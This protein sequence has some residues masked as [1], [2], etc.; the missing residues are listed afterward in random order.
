[1]LRTQ[2]KKNKK[3]MSG[4]REPAMEICVWLYQL[5]G[6][7]GYYLFNQCADMTNSTEILEKL[8]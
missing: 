8:A 2:M 5:W 7:L 1:M 4:H 3:T 6:H